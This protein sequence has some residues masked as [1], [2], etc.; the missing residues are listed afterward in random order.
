MKKLF[1]LMLILAL[2]WAAAA[3]AQAEDT[4]TLQV[5]D[6]VVFGR[7]DQDGDRHNELQ[8]LEWQVLEVK[9]GKAWIISR[10]GLDV[11]MY[12]KSAPFPTW[13]KSQMRQYLNGEF[14]DT[15]FTPEE[16]A[17]IEVTRVVTLDNSLWYF[18]KEVGRKYELVEDGTEVEDKMF[19]LSVQEVLQLCGV[20]TIPEQHES[21]EALEK[22]KAVATKH[23]EYSG[24]FVFR[25]GSDEC[26]LDGKGCCWWMLR[27]PGHLSN[28]LSYI[29]SRGNINSFHYTD[30]HRLDVC[31]RPACW[32][33]I[34][35]LQALEN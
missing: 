25:G 21:M 2:L 28:H 6:Y 23:A 32:V 26:R 8:P 19:L 24:A 5:G 10:Y 27:S 31:I 18:R 16:L 35:A 17:C 3:V 1:S 22:M 29:G 9:D 13:A 4:A 30:S 7:F 33:D 12:H 20:S 11:R 34:A 14:L 15:T